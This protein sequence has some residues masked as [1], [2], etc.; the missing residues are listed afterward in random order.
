MVIICMEIAEHFENNKDQY[1][2]IHIY[3]TGH[4]ETDTGNWCFSD[5]VI[6]LKDVMK[7][8]RIKRAGNRDALNLIIDCCYSGDWALELRQYKAW[9][10]TI[11]AASY[12]GKVAYD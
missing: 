5:G 11:N 7:K 1:R 9:L 4:G 6:S 2:N 10:A 12:P 3:Y 8:Y